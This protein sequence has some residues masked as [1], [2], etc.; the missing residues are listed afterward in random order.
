MSRANV[1]VSGTQHSHRAGARRAHIAT[2]RATF[3]G[4][5][6]GHVGGPL[7]G[8]LVVV[9]FGG[10]CCGS[11]RESLWWVTSRATFL[12]HFV[13]HVSVTFRGAALGSWLVVG[14]FVGHFCG[15][16]VVLAWVTSAFSEGLTCARQAAG[17]PVRAERCTCLRWIRNAQREA[18]WLDS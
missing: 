3:V 1:E 5:F 17:P 6:V 11:L 13:G 12:R 7:R 15:S 18:A 9:R 16:H 4:H 2:S 14:H 10:H 8:S